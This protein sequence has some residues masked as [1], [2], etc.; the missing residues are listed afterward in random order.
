MPPHWA[1]T[2][3]RKDFSSADTVATLEAHSCQLSQSTDRAAEP[4]LELIAQTADEDDAEGAM[5]Q[6]FR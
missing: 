3:P 2:G 5:D 4:H 1:I 6:L